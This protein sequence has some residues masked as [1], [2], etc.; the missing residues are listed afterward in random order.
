LLLA[1]EH[2]APPGLGFLQVGVLA[3]QMHVSNSDQ[4][5]VTLVHLLLYEAAHFLDEFGKM[6]QTPLH[7]FNFGVWV[8]I[9]PNFN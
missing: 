1:L 3:T 7:S 4:R 6:S 5:P 2:A 9:M 8:A